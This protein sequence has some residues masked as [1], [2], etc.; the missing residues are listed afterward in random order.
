[1]KKIGLFMLVACIACFSSCGPDS[2]VNPEPEPETEVIKGRPTAFELYTNTQDSYHY[3]N[4]N[5][6]SKIVYNSNSTI[7]DIHYSGNDITSCTFTYKPPQGGVSR[8]DFEKVGNNRINATMVFEYSQINYIIH[9]NANGLPVSYNLINDDNE[10]IDKEFTF[11]PNSNQIHQKK[12]YFYF[13]QNEPTVRRVN[14]YTYEYD[15]NPG[16]TSKINCPVWFR[17]FF[18]EV[19]VL[20]MSDRELS[21]YYNN[22]VKESS[23]AEEMGVNIP[24]SEI[25]EYHYTYDDEG[26][27]SSVIEPRL[28]STI[29]I[30]Y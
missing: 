9:L 29:T 21:N 28:K 7:M 4:E 16:T 19:V 17:L 25:L 30:K 1:M 24:G 10:R 27:P 2:E 18:S 3:I 22:V 11:L 23:T 12:D 26:Y 6:L 14:T 20:S 13:E 8:I 5:Q 15:N